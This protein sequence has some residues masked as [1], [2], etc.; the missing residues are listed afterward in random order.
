MDEVIDTS[1]TKQVRTRRTKAQLKKEK[2]VAELHDVLSTYSGRACFWRLLEDCGVFKPLYN[3]D[4]T[5]F[6]MNEG[7]REIGLRIL[8]LMFE[9]DTHAYD[10]MRLEAQKRN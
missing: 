1:D 9:S 8:D 3:Q 4:Q 6:F 10:K 2:E 5:R 7:N